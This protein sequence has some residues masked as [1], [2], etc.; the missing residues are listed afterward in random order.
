MSFRSADLCIQPSTKR[1]LRWLSRAMSGDSPK[2]MSADELGDKFLNKYIEQH[3]PGIR[4]LE[5]E[6]AAAEQRFSNSLRNTEQAA[7]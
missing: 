6:A 2:P 7:A 3:Y 1:R 5:Q 4:E